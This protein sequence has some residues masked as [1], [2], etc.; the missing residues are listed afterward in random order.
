VANSDK[1]QKKL[2]WKPQHSDL[3]TIVADAWKFAKT[4]G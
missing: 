3:R 2:G 4:R 1:L